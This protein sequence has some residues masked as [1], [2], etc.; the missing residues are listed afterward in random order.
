MSGQNVPLLILGKLQGAVIQR[1]I[2]TVVSIVMNF[3]M[4]H[5]VEGIHVNI[6]MVFL[7]PGCILVDT[8]QSFAIM[9]LNA[10]EKFASLL[11]NPRSFAC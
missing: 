8:E 10:Q 11:T 3:R 1:N 7:S 6:H 2:I 4:D 5:A 9:E